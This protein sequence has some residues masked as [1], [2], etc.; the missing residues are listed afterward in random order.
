MASGNYFGFTHG[1]TQYSQPQATTY[2][3]QQHASAAA[4]Q[5]TAQLFPA[6]AT[7]PTAVYAST[8]TPR[9]TQTA[10][11]DTA[12][13]TSQQTGGYGYSTPQRQDPTPARQTTQT[14]QD[15]TG[16]G[17]EQTPSTGAFQKQTYYQ[18]P[19]QQHSATESYFSQRGKIAAGKTGSVYTSGGGSGYGG[20]GH[21]SM[22]QKPS[23]PKVAPVVTYAYAAQTTAP[24]YATTS[25]SSYSG[26]SKYSG[27][28][29]E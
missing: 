18:A 10:T 13:A 22:S 3:A 14:Y 23:Q 28:F 24:T 16:Y 19:T 27:E 8:A 5:G 6:Q 17:F 1:G 12:Y 26:Q 20:G 25:S 9:Q 29:R 4:A 7:H 15:S 21:Q 2:T 11:Y